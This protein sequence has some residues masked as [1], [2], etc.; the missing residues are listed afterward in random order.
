MRR[1]LVEIVIDSFEIVIF[2]ETGTS[3]IDKSAIIIRVVFLVTEKAIVVLGV[4][5]K[6]VRVVLTKVERA[7]LESSIRN[8]SSTF[9]VRTL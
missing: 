6:A 8:R 4:G 3:I 9:L 2:F 5:A 1:R 7:I